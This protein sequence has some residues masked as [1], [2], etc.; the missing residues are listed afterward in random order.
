MKQNEVRSSIFDFEFKI[1]KFPRT[2]RL[3]HEKLLA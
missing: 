1:Q 2:Q 3:L